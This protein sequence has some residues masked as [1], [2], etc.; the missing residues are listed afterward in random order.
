[1]NRIERR[2]NRALKSL[3]Q[4]F[5]LL[6]G[7]RNIRGHTFYSKKLLPTSTVVDL[8]ANLGEFS[9][10]IAMKYGC[11]IIA[12][13]A[14]PELFE[15]INETPLIRKF[16]YAVAGSDGFVTFYESRHTS[17]GNIIGPKSNSTGNTFEV[18]SRKLSSLIAELGLKEIDLLKIDIEGAEIQLFDNIKDYD[19]M[20]IKQLSIEFHDSVSIPNVSTED[21][22]RV[23]NKLKSSGFYGIALGNKNVDW[24]FINKKSVDLPSS[25]KFYLNLRKQLSK[26]NKTLKL[27]R[28]YLRAEIRTA[29]S[30]Q[31]LF[32]MHPRRQCKSSFIR[33][34]AKGSLSILYLI[35]DTIFCWLISTTAIIY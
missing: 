26:I 21:V 27:N 16:N 18:E 15:E 31:V 25:A 3:G 28:Y 7:F 22:Q 9:K 23:I 35:E 30:F 8:G 14:S 1:M 24:L 34:L 6:F 2:I 29:K 4:M 17:A 5:G 11:K 33:G 13:E 10:R 19:L 12:V 32:K 20:C